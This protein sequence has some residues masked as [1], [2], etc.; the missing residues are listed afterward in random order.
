MNKAK[1]LFF[2]FIALTTLKV[3]SQTLN[4]GPI[5]IQ[6]KVR[7]VNV[8]FNQTDQGALGIGFVPDELRFKFWARDR[9][10]VD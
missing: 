9:N 6:V 1:F 8:T 5:Q 2:V 4:D 3:F 7:D 10:D